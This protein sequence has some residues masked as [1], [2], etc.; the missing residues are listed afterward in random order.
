M[1]F[2]FRHPAVCDIANR[3][4]DDQ[5]VQRLPRSGLLQHAEEGIPAGAINVC[6][7]ILGGVTA[8]RIDQHGI[9]S[10]PPVA[11]TRASDTRDRSL[12][13]LLGQREP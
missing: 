6:V 9:F 11:Q 3:E 12:A 4:G 8:S 5:T 7:G 10:E 2:A 13:H 1:L